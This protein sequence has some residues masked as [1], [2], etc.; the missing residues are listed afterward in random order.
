MEPPLGFVERI[1]KFLSYFPGRMDE[2]EELLTRNRIWLA[3]TKG[4]GVLSAEDALDFGVSGP[5]L[6]AS[7]VDWDL[8]RDHP[9]SS[10]EKFSF[11]VPVRTEGDVYARY[12]LRLAEMRE[13]IKIVQQ[14]LDGL[15]EGPVMA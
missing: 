8:R 4:V 15:P 1:R 9:Y 5:S 6:R 11:Q 13:S 7:G 3:R 12:L 14:A 10:Y 2:Y